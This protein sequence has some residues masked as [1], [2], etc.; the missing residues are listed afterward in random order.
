MIYQVSYVV[1]DGGHPGTIMNQEERPEVG[2]RV[3]FA[4]ETVEIVEVL[5]IIPPRNDFAYLH[6]TC[7]VVEG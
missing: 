2:D 1:I 7:K 5:E 6:A 4:G 3:E